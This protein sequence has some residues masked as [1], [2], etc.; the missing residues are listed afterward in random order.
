MSE[1]DVKLEADDT[2]NCSA[3]VNES[4]EEPNVTEE[5]SSS[6]WY[7]VLSVDFCIYFVVNVVLSTVTRDISRSEGSIALSSL[8][9]L[10]TVHYTLYLLKTLYCIYLV[11]F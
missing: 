2:L 4:S 3:E 6:S 10:S 8:L 9:V 5:M 1:C 11:I 7:S